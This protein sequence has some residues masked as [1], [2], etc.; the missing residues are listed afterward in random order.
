MAAKEEPEK[1]KDIQIIT[2]EDGKDFVRVSRGAC[3][4]KYDFNKGLMNAVSNY[5]DYSFKSIIKLTTNN[6]EDLVTVASTQDK[7]KHSSIIKEIEDCIIKVSIVE[8]IN[9]DNYSNDKSYESIKTIFDNAWKVP[10][11]VFASSIM[12]SPFSPI[13]PLGNIHFKI[14]FLILRTSSSYF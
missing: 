3:S 1:Y 6:D 7:Y 14:L 2:N 11:S 10:F 9:T 12:N 13:T 4:F 8:N 5:L